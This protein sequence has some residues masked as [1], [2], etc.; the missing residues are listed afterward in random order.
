MHEVIAFIC[1]FRTF[2]N[3]LEL[4]LTSMLVYLVAHTIKVGL[5]LVVIIAQFETKPGMNLT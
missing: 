3:S 2:S 4:V 5:Y 1:F